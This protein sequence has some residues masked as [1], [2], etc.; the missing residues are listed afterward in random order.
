MVPQDHGLCRGAPVGTRP[1]RNGPSTS[2]R[3][4]GTGSAGAG[5][6]RPFRPR[7]GRRRRIEV[8]TTRIDTIY[9]ATF[10]VLSPE[11]P[12]AGTSSPGRAK[13]SS[14]PGSRRP[15]PQTRLKREIGETGEGRRRHREEGAQPLHRGAH[16]DL[17]G[18]L[19]PHGIRDGRHHG[20]PGPRRQ[21][22]RVR[23]EYGLPIRTVIVP[24]GKRRRPHE[25]RRPRSSRTSASWSIPGRS[26]A[27]LGGRHG[28]DGGLCRGKGLRPPEHRLP[29]ARLG[30]LPPALLGHARSP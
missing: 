2:S 7:P 20:R 17:A 12:R 21:R 30:H 4:R 6:P 23:P 8:F 22:F 1:S 10:L 18:Q 15:S 11:H 27:C 9:G 5:R 28:Q 29:A 13:P 19:R 26:P 3:C 25:G 16:P 14:R 24:P